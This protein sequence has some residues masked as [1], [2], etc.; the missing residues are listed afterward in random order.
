MMVGRRSKLLRYIWRKDPK[1]CFELAKKLGI[2]TASF[3]N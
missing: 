3:K 2:R 1:R